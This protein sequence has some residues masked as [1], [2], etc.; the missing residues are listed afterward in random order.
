MKDLD[1]TIAGLM[2][3]H[4]L[5]GLAIVRRDGIPAV[6]RFRR[7]A[8]E[9]SF[10]A[11]MAAAWGAIEA[12]CSEWTSAPPTHAVVAADGLALAIG[13]LDDEVLIVVVGA[14]GAGASEALDP[15]RTAIVALLGV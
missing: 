2:E 7:S 3:Q 10:A 5:M 4:A 11:M 1:E 6:S 9:E 13:G 12:A 15:C 14:S 8:D